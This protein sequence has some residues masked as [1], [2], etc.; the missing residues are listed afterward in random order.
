MKNKLVLICFWCSLALAACSGAATFSTPQAAAVDIYGTSA[1]AQVQLERSQLAMT[2]TAQAQIIPITQT[3]AAFAIAQAQ[4]EATERAIATASSSA[5]TGTASAWTPTP[6]F[7]QTVQAA[8]AS[9]TVQSLSNDGIRD[10]LAVE[11]T[12]VMNTAYAFMPIFF[13]FLSIVVAV[14]FGLSW[15]RRVAVISVPVDPR[16][17]PQ[18]MLDVVDGTAIDID[19]MANA[20]SGMR[21]IDLKSLPV[22]TAERQDA[23]TARDQQVDL[24][25]RLPAPRKM[26]AGAELPLALTAAADGDGASQN[27]LAATSFA[28]PSWTQMMNWDGKGGLPVGV[29]A[30]GLEFV[31]LNVHPHIGVIGKTGAGKSRRF[32]RPFIAG[33][34]RAGHK[35]AILGKMVDFLPFKNHPSV[36]MFSIRELTIEQEATRYALILRSLVEE[37]NKRDAILTDEGKSTWSQT[38]RESTLI[39]LDEL[40]NALDLM[41]REQSIASY[42]YINGLVKEGRKVGF[43]LM[44]A[45]QRAKGFRDIMTQVG[46]A[47]FYV[48]DE[49]ESRN[50]LGVVG[51]E[52]LKEG[53]FFGRFGAR[54]LMGSFAPSDQDLVAF[55]NNGAHGIAGDG[56]VLNLDVEDHDGLSA[57]QL[58]RAQELKGNGASMT[59]IVNDLFGSAGGAAFYPRAKMIREALGM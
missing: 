11:R 43:N 21:R 44:F 33:A 55:L 38:G 5:A 18:P 16:G 20:V 24:I 41:P 26:L 32:L 40:G 36:S 49:M 10:D 46:R 57:E 23:V 35:V 9:A 42:R 7:T 15:A 45:S 48:E 13:A 52:S 28:L 37:M 4:A 29:S 34:I 3:A 56:D 30:R 47:V 27:L 59:A 31:D 39:I 25:T 6:N 51:A 19:R 12:R 1:A 8:E 14:M 50:A 22:I 2:A 58:R 53:Y 17:N 54:A